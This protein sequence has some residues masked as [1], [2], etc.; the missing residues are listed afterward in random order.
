MTSWQATEW[1]VYFHPSTDKRWCQINAVRHTK[2]VAWNPNKCLKSISF[3]SA[4]LFSY[5]CAQDVVSKFAN[6][7]M[8]LTP[9]SFS[10]VVRHCQ[11]FYSMESLT[12]VVCRFSLFILFVQIG[13]RWDS[14]REFGDRGRKADVNRSPVIRHQIQLTADQIEQPMGTAENRGTFFL[15][16]YF[17]DRPKTLCVAEADPLKYPLRMI[18]NILSLKYYKLGNVYCIRSDF[19]TNIWA[20]WTR[21]FHDQQTVCSL[22]NFLRHCISQLNLIVLLAI[23]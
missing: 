15:M 19:G 21:V 12:Q 14:L 17:F 2:S 9:L 18:G 16:H 6:A 20:T 3:S 7:S 8:Q 22:L 1:R 13:L 11:Y 4:P 5:H 23:K 10:P